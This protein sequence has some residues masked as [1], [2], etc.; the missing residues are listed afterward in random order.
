[1]MGYDMSWAAFWVVEV[2]SQPWFGHKRLAYLAASQSFT[3]DTEVALLTVHS[4]K[5]V[6]I[7][8]SISTTKWMQT[9]VKVLLKK[10][11]VFISFFG[12]YSFHNRRLALCLQVR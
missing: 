4:F 7:A 2:M 6:H 1:M 10:S 9:Y 5:K 3:V 11:S 12:N 8:L